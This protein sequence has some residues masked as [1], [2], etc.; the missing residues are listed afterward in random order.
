MD[1]GVAAGSTLTFTGTFL[2][3]SV[4]HYVTVNWHLLILMIYD[5]FPGKWPAVEDQLRD[6]FDERRVLGFPV[7]AAEMTLQ[8]RR[9]FQ[10]W[11]TELP[12]GEREEFQRTRPHLIPF[13]ASDGWLTNSLER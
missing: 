4:M 7:A 8:A 5:Y 10:R 9:M 6:W 12:H 13:R 1:N 2:L 3:R 11:W